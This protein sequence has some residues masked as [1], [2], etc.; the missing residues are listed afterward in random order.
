MPPRKVVPIMNVSS[1]TKRSQHHYQLNGEEAKRA[2]AQNS[3][4]SPEGDES[5]PP[6]DEDTSEEG[7]TTEQPHDSSPQS[8][9]G[10]MSVIARTRLGPSQKGRQ[11]AAAR[12]DEPVMGMGHIQ[13]IVNWVNSIVTEAVWQ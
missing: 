13:N 11:P 9:R 3:Q 2:R 12:Q 4:H 10:L 6:R 5:L 8:G 7:E 1:R